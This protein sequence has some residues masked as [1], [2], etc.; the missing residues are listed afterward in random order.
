MCDQFPDCENDFF[1]TDDYEQQDVE[2]PQ[3]CICG[4]NIAADIHGRLCASCL[5]YVKLN[6]HDNEHDYCE[7]DVVDAID[8][9]TE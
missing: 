1:D 9:S 4:L 3:K 8:N 7:H 5:A 6:Y 2:F